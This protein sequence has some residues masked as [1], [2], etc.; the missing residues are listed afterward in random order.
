MARA[1]TT[2]RSGILNALAELF[3]R[4]DGGDGYKTDLTGAISTRMTFW[5]EVD[6]FP[7]LHMSAG[8]ETREYYG[9][10]QKFRFLTVTILSLIHI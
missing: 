6:V 8:P 5:D 10:G 7:S 2:R 1:Q 9:G 3:Q 4:I